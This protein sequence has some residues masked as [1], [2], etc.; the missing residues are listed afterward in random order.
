MFEN[1][2]QTTNFQVP[3]NEISYEWFAM[4]PNLCYSEYLEVAF[5]LSC[6]LFG[7]ISPC[8]STLKNLYTAPLCIWNFA[9]GKLNN[10]FGVNSGL[11]KC[12]KIPSESKSDFPSLPTLWQLC[13]GCSWK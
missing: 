6:G 5:C 9:Y 13:P 1:R 11:N 12:S 8:R 10:H 3:T 4:Y 7:H 2:P